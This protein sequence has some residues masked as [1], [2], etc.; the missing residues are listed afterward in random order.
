MIIVMGKML[1]KLIPDGVLETDVD[2]ISKEKS[3]GLNPPDLS[4]DIW[5]A[6]L[7]TAGKGRGK[8]NCMALMSA[9]CGFVLVA[10]LPAASIAGEAPTE[11]EI[12]AFK[13]KLAESIL[14]S[15]T[16]AFRA[17]GLPEDRITAYVQGPLMYYRG[18]STT[19]SVRLEV[20]IKNHMVWNAEDNPSEKFDVAHENIGE[21]KIGNS[22]LYRHVE[23]ATVNM[24]ELTEEEKQ[25]WATNFIR[26]LL[27]GSEG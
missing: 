12:R 22:P 13:D 11:D 19:P 14:G 7:T 26:P 21:R 27:V 20:F 15:M 5:S 4:K 1:R 8:R 2:P 3:T 17:F 23:E 25:A 9:N 24:L 6:E 10:P 18:K 16:K